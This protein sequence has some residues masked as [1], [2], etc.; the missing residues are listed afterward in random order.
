MFVLFIFPLSGTR[1]RRLI[2]VGKVR[3]VS[4]RLRLWG[5]QDTTPFL[6]QYR[7]PSNST[8]SF[9]ISRYFDFDLVWRISRSIHWARLWLFSTRHEENVVPQ[10]QDSISRSR[11]T[12]RN[13]RSLWEGIQ[14]NEV[15]WGSSLGGNEGEGKGEKSAGEEVGFEQSEEEKWKLLRFE[16]KGDSDGRTKGQPLL[17]LHLSSRDG[18]DVTSI[19]WQLNF[20]FPLPTPSSATQSPRSTFLK[21]LDSAFASATSQLL[22]LPLTSSS[23]RIDISNPSFTSSTVSSST[24]ASPVDLQANVP[25]ASLIG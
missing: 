15:E 4:I 8:S 22:F 16:G 5:C 9:G 21:I 24:W 6:F 3:T 14:N 2:S 7:S 10:F 18:T 12:C 11:R 1:H 20:R 25:S 19:G 13:H 23:F 17:H